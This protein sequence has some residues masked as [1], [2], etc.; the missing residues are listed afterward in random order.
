[1]ES[2]CEAMHYVTSLS[3]ATVTTRFLVQTPK[4][5]ISTEK[6]FWTF[7]VAL[8]FAFLTLEIREIRNNFE[9]IAITI[10]L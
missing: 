1:M 2:D 9:I 3:P 7:L 8:F 10:L 6:C 4:L 5:A